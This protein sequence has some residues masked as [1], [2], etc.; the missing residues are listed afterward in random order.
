[1]SMTGVLAE[2]PALSP[3]IRERVVS[4]TQSA[5]PF[6]RVYR[7]HETIQSIISTAAVE[8]RPI[9]PANVVPT[10][11]RAYPESNPA[12]LAE[13]VM[14]AATEAGVTLTA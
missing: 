11:S 7:L 14:Q 10:L 3:A 1:M 12:E 4:S 9:S 6:G 13:A 8:G 5:S 2:R